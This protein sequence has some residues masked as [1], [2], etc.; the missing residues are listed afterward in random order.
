VIDEALLRLRKGNRPKG[1]SKFAGFQLV[2]NEALNAASVQ[3]TANYELT[4]T[5][6]KGRRIANQPVRFKVDYVTAS[7]TVDVMISGAVPTFA[8]GG[9]LVLR[10]PGITSSGGETLVGSTVFTILAH[11]R[12]I[13]G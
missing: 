1:P 9:R 10:A 8:K 5:V 2:F 6:K 12:G 11:A 7:K 13:T 3:N 4:Q